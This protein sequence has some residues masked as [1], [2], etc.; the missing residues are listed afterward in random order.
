MKF[1]DKI[2]N[3]LFIAL[4]STSVLSGED[5]NRST[6][7]QY[8]VPQLETTPVEKGGGLLMLY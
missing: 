2:S 1:G 3:F 5:S 8:V 7:V 6:P 4:F